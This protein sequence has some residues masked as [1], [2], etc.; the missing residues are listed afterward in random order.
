VGAGVGTHPKAHAQ[1]SYSIVL[2]ACVPPTTVTVDGEV[3]QYEPFVSVTGKLGVNTWSYDGSQLAVVI[4]L[5]RRF[6]V[7]RDVVVVAN[8]PQ[9]QQQW[10]RPKMSGVR[11]VIARARMLKPTLDN[12]YPRAYPVRQA[13]YAP[14]PARPPVLTRFNCLGPLAAHC[15]CRFS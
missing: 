15:V 7:T 12:W 5:F 8:L 10:L 11:G 9:G 2:H 14:Q 13:F 1:R 4:N 6:D 3:V